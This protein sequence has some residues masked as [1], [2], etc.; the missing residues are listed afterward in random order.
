MD[1]TYGVALTDRH[2][3]RIGQVPSTINAENTA[4]STTKNEPATAIPA[5]LREDVPLDGVELPEPIRPLEHLKDI[6]I[7]RA[8]AVGLL[9][10][11]AGLL[12]VALVLFFHT[13]ARMRGSFARR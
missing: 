4:T 8:D 10:G 1:D 7:G 5:G 12:A 3:Q 11:A 9:A 2:V 13:A 6:L